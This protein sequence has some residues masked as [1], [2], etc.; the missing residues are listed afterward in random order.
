MKILPL[1]LIALYFGMA[2]SYAQT[3]ETDSLAY[4]S[5]KLKLEEVNLVSG[6]Y[7]Q[8]G[9][10]SAV[11]GGIGTEKLSDLANTIDLQVTKYGKTMLKH[12]F[13]FELGIDTYTS[14]SSDKIDPISI[15]SAS[16]SDVRVYP[17]LGWTLT[18]EKSG[19]SFGLVGSYSTE[20]DYQSFG[21]GFNFNLLSKDKNREFGFKAQA[22]LD[23][24]KVIYPSELR[25]L[26]YGSSAEGDNRPV[27]SAPRNSFST[28]LS[29]SQVINP[30]L[31]ALIMVEPSMQ[32]GM[33][34][35]QYQRVYFANNNIERIEKLPG[36]RYKLPVGLRLNYFATD[37]VIF[38]SFYRYYTDNWGIKANTAELEVPVKLTS[39]VS[40]SPF[41]RYYK[42]TASDYF[43][44][45][46]Q[47]QSAENNY[48]SDYDLSAFHS[49]FF[50]AGFRLASPKGVFNI[51]R[52]NMAE[53][54]FG[55]Y[56]R[57][58]GLNSNQIS[59]NLKFK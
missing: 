5:R 45:Y 29:L 50:G 59:L 25:P 22:F 8:D 28:Q 42:Q 34:A 47:H 33:L 19:N 53:I 56:I 20:W 35:T 48:T 6:Y 52:L 32:K 17:S 26:G 13:N 44:P 51:N 23:T 15:S 57:S 31:Q 30:K 24:W 9:N 2:A 27:D 10:N 58:N 16:I 4:K 36:K 54:R 12:T 40:I 14:A 49:N 43:A 3:T 38:R 1:G 39:F 21:G 55:H 11:T 41:Y 18:N 37:K 7:H 46:M